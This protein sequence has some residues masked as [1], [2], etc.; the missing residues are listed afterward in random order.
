MSGAA[1]KF[2]M[3]DCGLTMRKIAAELN[4]SYST[5]NSIMNNFNG[6]SQIKVNAVEKFISNCEQLIADT[7]TLETWKEKIIR[8]CNNQKVMI[9]EIIKQVK[10]SDGEFTPKP[11][12]QL[13][14]EDDAMLDKIHQEGREEDE[15]EAF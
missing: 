10:N 6:V 13:S 4:L 3:K 14:P 1:L 9:D 12:Y 7:E 8:L 5:V 2:R 11:K 15:L